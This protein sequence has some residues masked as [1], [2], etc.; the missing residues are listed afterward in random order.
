MVEAE[1]DP[2]P[3]TFEGT[4]A[5]ACVRRPEEP[6]P[7]RPVAPFLDS[8]ESSAAVAWRGATTKRTNLVYEVGA[9]EGAAPR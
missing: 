9:V 2:H 6:V 5:S 8:T 1:V 7:H 3:E 4:K